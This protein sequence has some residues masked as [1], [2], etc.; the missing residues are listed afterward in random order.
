MDGYI[1]RWIGGCVCMDGWMDALFVGC[2]G[3]WIDGCMSGW[4]VTCLGS[5][6]SR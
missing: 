6:M 5:W 2:V 3:W 4:I 1:V